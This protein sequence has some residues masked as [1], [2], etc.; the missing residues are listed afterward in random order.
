MKKDKKAMELKKTWVAIGASVVLASQMMMVGG[1][2]ADPAKPAA[3]L[4][5]SPAVQPKVEAGAAQ[6]NEAGQ[7]DEGKRNAGAKPKAEVMTDNLSKYG[8]KKDM[9][10]PVTVEAGGLSYT[11]HKVMIYDFNSKDVQ[12]LRKKFNYAAS[13]GMF[14]NP[15]YFIWTKITI[16][17]NSK[18]TIDNMNGSTKW[19]LQTMD[20]KRFD[21]VRSF[22]K[23]GKVNDKEA[24]NSFK[25]KP[26]E[27][28]TTYQAFYFDGT[29]DYF[30]VSMSFKGS[31]TEKYVVVPEELRGK[32]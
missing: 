11:L 31:F 8:L 24:L 21:P 9:E 25:L 3:S 12:V 16:K 10:L 17:N 32:Q 6:K 4:A 29:F 13:S 7:S 5:A 19:S 1:A 27:S 14:V 23:I 20:M 15:K 26:N 22:S 28:L 30:S 2:A 18:S